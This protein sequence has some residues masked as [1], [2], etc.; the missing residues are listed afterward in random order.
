MVSA[1]LITTLSCNQL[2]SIIHRVFQNNQLTEGQKIGI[3][4]ELRS[5]IPS[6]PIIIKSNETKRT[7]SN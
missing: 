1:L 5:S 2:F 3:L 4:K 6:C 7:S